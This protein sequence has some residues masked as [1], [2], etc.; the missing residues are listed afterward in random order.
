MPDWRQ[1]KGQICE[2]ILT[3]YLLHLGYYVMRP[4]A[5]QGPV[6]IIAYDDHGSLYLLDSKADSQR[7]LP[8]RTKPSRIHRSLSKAQRAL[9]VRVAYVDMESRTVHIVPPL[10][11]GAT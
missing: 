11:D 4:L 10:D 5:G 9:G 6:D 1:Q 7:V 8:N 2:T 3:E